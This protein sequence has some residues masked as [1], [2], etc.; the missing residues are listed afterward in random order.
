MARQQFA[1]EADPAN[2]G[3]AVLFAE[4]ETLGQ[5]GPDDIPVEHLDPATALAENLLQVAGQRGLPGS[6]QAGQPDRK[7]L[8]HSEL[9]PQTQPGG[10]PLCATDRSD[11]AA[12]R[13]RRRQS[14]PLTAR[15]ELGRVGCPVAS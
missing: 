1:D 8:F 13:C 11:Q 7:A 14:R 6:G 3:V 4:A 10:A 12:W 15:R 9:L 2:V 5:V